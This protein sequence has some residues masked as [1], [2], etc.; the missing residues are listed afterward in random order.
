M[1]DGLGQHPAPTHVVAHVSDT[2]LLAGGA[3]LGGA[4]DT[5]EHLRSVLERLELAAP[6][7]D[8]LVVSG[9]C[10]D[11]GEPEAYALLRELVEPVAARMGARVVYAAGNHDERGPMWRALHDIDEAAPY[12]HV[13]DVGGLRIVSLDSSLPGF[14]HGGFDDGQAQWLA[15]VL[16]EPAQHGTLLVMHHPPL[17]YRARIMQVL[18][19]QDERRLAEV[20]AGSDVRAILSGHLHV[21]GSGTF[22]GIPVIL[23]N[24]TS[25]ADDLA[26]GPTAFQGI[27]A[28]QSANLLEVYPHTVAHSVV[29][30]RAHPSLSPLP[31]DL[32]ARLAAL[33]A[34]GRVERFSRKR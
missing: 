31:A 26:A 24:A 5:A 3:L 10:T 9:D 22:A 33:D 14:H 25:Y 32:H 21:N 18:E 11:L 8:A 27:D 16:A 6:T 13:H 28:A 20:L 23:A 15:D 19:F 29:P 1:H 4:I 12:D 17:P 34:A 30:G 7:A 2:H